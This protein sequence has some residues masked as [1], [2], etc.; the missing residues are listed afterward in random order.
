[1]KKTN[2]LLLF[3][4]LY[5]LTNAQVTVSVNATSIAINPSLLGLNGRSTEGPSWTD[6]TFIANV[7][8]MNPAY[9][10][11]PAGTQG[12]QWNWKT[13][14]FIASLNMRAREIY[15]IPMLLNGLPKGAKIIYMINMVTP[16]EQ[17]GIT[18][19]DINDPKLATDVTLSAKITDIL[20]AIA[21][22]ER[23]GHLPEVV[24]LGNELDF[25]NLHGGVYSNNATFYLQH[26]KIIA[27]AIKSIYPTIKLIL[28]T[29]KGGTANREN[30]NQTVFSALNTDGSLRAMI[31]GVVQH[32]YINKNYG[33]LTTITTNAL[34][35]TIIDEGIKYVKEV[36][37]D[38][39]IVPSG[40]KLWITEYGATK[41]N[42][43]GMW[44]AGMRYATMTLQFMKM[45]SKVDNLMWQ[46]I[47]HVPNMLNTTKTMLGPAGMAFAQLTK[48]MNGATSYK[49][50]VFSNMSATNDYAGL[51]GYKFFADG[52]ENILILNTENITY[53]NLN[54]STLFTSGTTQFARQ[55]WSATP[56]VF[57]VSPTSNI[58]VNSS[59]D[60]ASYQINPFSIT[61]LSKEM[62]TANSKLAID[63]SVKLYPT[64]IENGFVKIECQHKS[65]FT[66]RDMI[67]KQLS[68][69]ILNSGENTIDT[70]QFSKGINFVFI[71]NKVFKVIK[72]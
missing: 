18:F 36:A 6:N 30:W 43:D 46:H 2:L 55:Y 26:A 47:T 71:E 62:N 17:T 60:L 53:N 13:G 45:G 15:T 65:V 38:Y 59:T 49:K 34:A 68:S 8:E 35:K 19:T 56:Y 69:A 32:H 42:A 28:C 3:I 23:L 51:T 29:T 66:V 12:N 33:I 27:T 22:F 11:Y 24:E 50:L 48:A 41:A 61:V 57:G 58:S 25:A 64:I 4:F 39:T 67:G 54:L 21:E 37:N 72:K 14:T 9:V 16:T 5:S 7:R 44:C 52:V 70:K 40:M 10:R 63:S 20:N 1:M 31:Y